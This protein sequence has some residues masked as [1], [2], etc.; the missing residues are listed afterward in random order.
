MIVATYAKSGATWTQ[1]II[2]QLAFKGSPD[3]PIHEISP[4]VDLL[5]PPKELKLAEPEAQ[6]HRRMVKTHP[7]LDA[8]VLNAA[9][10][11]IYIGQDGGDVVWGFRHHHSATN[12]LWYRVLNDTPG[13][14]GPPIDPP[15]ADIRR[16][17]LTW[18]EKDGFPIWSCWE[19]ITTWWA[20]RSLPNVR[21]M[22]F[23]DRKADLPGEMKPIANFLDIDIAE[24]EWPAIIE[25]CSFDDMK[26]NADK[27]AP[28][29]GAVFEGGSREFINK[30]ANG[31]WREI[32]TR[33]DVAH[34][35]RTAEEKL[36]TECARWLSTGTT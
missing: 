36:G 29:G 19:N 6:T 4:G 1:H 21:L 14:I 8:L 5:A 22:H 7:P 35:E 2:G 23:N 31:R 30:G 33:E 9:A 12:A 20:A 10:R 15:D 26:K 3:M 25:H 13:R 18:L 24:A 28:R 27:V 17:F 16:F 34:D 11:Y 32:L